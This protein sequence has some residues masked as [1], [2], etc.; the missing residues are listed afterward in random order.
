MLRIF[1]IVFLLSLMAQPGYGQYAT[2]LVPDGGWDQFQK[3]I[4]E[5]LEVPYGSNLSGILYVSTVISEKGVMQSNSITKG[6]GGYADE[7]VL[8]VI[9]KLK[10]KFVPQKSGSEKMKLTFPVYY[11][12]SEEEISQIQSETPR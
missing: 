10:T 7:Q 1:Y 9:N 3:T 4:Q 6:I 11:N 2:D 12:L 8:A 5:R